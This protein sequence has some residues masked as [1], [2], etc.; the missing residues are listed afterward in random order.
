MNICFGCAAKMYASDICPVC[1]FDLKTYVA[2]PHHL[3][4]GSLLRERYL[5]GKALGEGGF[6]ITYIK[7]K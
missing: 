5:I 4:P 6:G 3:I 2:E 7:I 1:G